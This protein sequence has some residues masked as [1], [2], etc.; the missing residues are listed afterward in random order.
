MEVVRRTILSLVLTDHLVK[1]ELLATSLLL[2]LILFKLRLNFQA[3]EFQVVSLVRKAL[4]ANSI[5]SASS[6]LCQLVLNSQLS[7]KF[8]ILVFLR[9]F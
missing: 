6:P 8:L 1:L 9:T 4:P 5:E 3:L 7:L 2:E